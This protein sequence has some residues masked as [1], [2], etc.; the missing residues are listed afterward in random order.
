ML[1]LEAKIRQEKG[2]KVKK[3]R[4]EGILPAVLYGPSL[5]PM[6]LEVDKKEFEKIYEKA[7]ESSLISLEVKGKEYPVLIHQIQRDPIKEEILHVDFYHPSAKKKVEARVPLVFEGVAPAVKELGGTLIKN[8]SEVHLKGLAKNLPREI[9][10]NL[11]KLKNFEDLITVAD[12]KLP[13]GVEVKERKEEIIAHV[14]PPEKEEK[15]E[16]KVE[17]T[18]PLEKP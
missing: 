4:K 18:A 1:K 16:E 3:L 2:K 6:N 7:G 15:E 9:K 5:K 12:L 17:E 14:L 8:L 13:P 10:I 11:G